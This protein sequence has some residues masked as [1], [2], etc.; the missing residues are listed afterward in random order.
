M[1]SVG[2]FSIWIHEWS[3]HCQVPTTTQAT[4]HC[5]YMV[6]QFGYFVGGKAGKPTKSVGKV[7]MLVLPHSRQH[8]LD[9]SPWPPH[10][11]TGHCCTHQSQDWECAYVLLRTWLIRLR[12][13][14]WLSFAVASL[15]RSIY[16]FDAESS[17]MSWTGTRDAPKSNRRK[18]LT[19]YCMLTLFLITDAFG[20]CRNYCIDLLLG[21]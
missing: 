18:W 1:K 4:L 12:Q 9:T 21:R 13:Q 11:C 20:H 16:S 10:P 19:L 3:A 8:V 15:A 6:W 14:P 17:A 5:S 2:A 7:K